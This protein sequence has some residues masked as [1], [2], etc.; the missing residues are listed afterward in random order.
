[1]KK[2]VVSILL[3]VIL[4]IG[5]CIGGSSEIKTTTKETT[6]TQKTVTTEETTTT[7]CPIAPGIYSS[8][9]LL[10]ASK[11]GFSKVDVDNW[12]VDESTD[13]LFIIFENNAGKEIVIKQ[14]KVRGEIEKTTLLD[15]TMADDEKSSEP[16]II[17][18]PEISSGE[19]YRWNVI[20]D[21]YLKQYG[22][23]PTFSSSGTLIG[24]A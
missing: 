13:K 2:I 21:Y 24:L 4:F 3:I 7:W 10:G 6:T 14:V 12:T 1:M 19:S 20:I 16:V 9:G 23:E 22:E 17:D 11:V 5:G 18:C 8:C 15:I